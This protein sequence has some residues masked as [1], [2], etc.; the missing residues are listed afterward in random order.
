MHGAE[1]ADASEYRVEG[2]PVPDEDHGHLPGLGDRAGQ[3]RRQSPGNSVCGEGFCGPGH[4]GDAAV[5]NLYAQ[6]IDEFGYDEGEEEPEQGPV[7]GREVYR[8]T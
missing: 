7:H 4:A 2:R 5:D 3:E 6:F 1:P 8:G